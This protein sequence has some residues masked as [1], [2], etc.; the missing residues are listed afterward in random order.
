MLVLN[1]H[2]FNHNPKGMGQ[3]AGHIPPPSPPKKKKKKKNH[4][5]IFHIWWH[6]HNESAISII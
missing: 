6:M 5:H 3:S 2:I 4:T 1:G